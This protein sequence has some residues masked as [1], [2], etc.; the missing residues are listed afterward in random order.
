MKN[1]ISIILFIFILPSA[2]AKF[3]IDLGFGLKSK[4]LTGVDKLTQVEGKLVGNALMQTRFNILW[5]LSQKWQ[6]LID[7]ASTTVDFDN[8]DNVITGP[9]SVT[10]SKTAIGARWIIMPRAA[11]RFY[12]S[13]E[14]DVAFGLNGSSPPQAVLYTE[15]INHIDLWYDQIVFMGGSMYSGFR[16]GYGL[17]ASGAKTIDRS[18]TDIALFFV[19]DNWDF[20]YEFTNFTK[21]NSELDFVEKDTTIG[22]KYSLK[23]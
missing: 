7:Y 3:N 16:V 14:Q 21:S 23:F 2:Q 8:S 22:V 1:I 12:Y 6:L 19:W 13:M 4:S 11:F 17:G 20:S 10:L 15:T 5:G 9:D 18:G